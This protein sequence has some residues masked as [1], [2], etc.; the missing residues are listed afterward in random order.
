MSKIFHVGGAKAVGKTVILSELDGTLSPMG[1][2][3]TTLH[4]SELLEE[5]S[6]KDYAQTWK[7]LSGEQRSSLRLKLLEVVTNTDSPVTLLDSHLIDMKEDTPKVILPP[8]FEPI[9]DGYIVITAHPDVILT[10]RYGDQDF[11][12]RDMDPNRIAVEAEAEIQAAILYSA[13]L[14]LKPLI[15]ENNWKPDTMH[16]I[17]DGVDQFITGRMGIEGKGNGYEG[18]SIHH[19]E[20]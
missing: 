20:R 6:Q 17:L 15:V 2:H 9:I 18:N 11:R 14:G 13:K 5:L 4:M 16:G 1:N 10:R 7:S 12:E 19:I 8:E 3:V